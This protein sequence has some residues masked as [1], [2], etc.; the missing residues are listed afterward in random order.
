MYSTD[1]YP[2]ALSFT[3]ENRLLTPSIKGWSV[4]GFSGPRFPPSALRSSGRHGPSVRATPRSADSSPDPRPAVPEQLPGFFHILPLVDT[5]KHQPHPPPPFQLLT[6]PG[7]GPA[8]DLPDRVARRHLTLYYIELVVH[9]MR[10]PKYVDHSISVGG[11]HVD[12]HILDGLEMPVVTQ[13]FRK[14]TSP[15]P[16]HL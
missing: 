6:L 4:L 11:A 14:Q 13:K 16:L 5:L 8:L 2:R 15:K 1:R 7:V 9:H 3:A 12:G 10:V